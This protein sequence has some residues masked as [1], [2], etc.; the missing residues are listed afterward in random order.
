MSDKNP[1]DV[2]FSIRIDPDIKLQATE[3]LSKKGLTINDFCR[4][5][6]IDVA[7]YG[8]PDHP[9]QTPEEMCKAQLE[10]MCK[11]Y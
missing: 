2:L 1:K 10:A 3:E 5:L 6:L 8:L 7:H 11:R 9:G 4:M